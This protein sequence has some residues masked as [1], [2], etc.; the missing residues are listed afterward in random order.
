MMRRSS[1]TRTMLF[2]LLGVLTLALATPP[3]AAQPAAPP[4]EEKPAAGARPGMPQGMGP[5]GMP[6]GMMGGMH[7]GMMG[8]MGP[9]GMHGGM[10][11]A[12]PMMGMMGGMASPMM[13]AGGDPRTMGLMLQMRGEMMRAVG[14]VL[15][16]YGQ[17]LGAGN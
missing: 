10:M 3:L 16:K 6:G 13:G 2:A 11:G 1:G 5:G 9:G 15:L 12:C 8:G 7:G 17:Q 4:A 14:E